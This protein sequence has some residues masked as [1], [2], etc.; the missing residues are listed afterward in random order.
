MIRTARLWARDLLVAAGEQTKTR[1]LAATR[2]QRNGSGDERA[3]VKTRY[4][5]AL[6]LA[7]RI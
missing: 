5:V 1:P 2:A 3:G 6:G 4:Q 7:N